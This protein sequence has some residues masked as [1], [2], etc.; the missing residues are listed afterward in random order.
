MNAPHATTAEQLRQHLLRLGV[1]G[2]LEAAIVTKAGRGPND[3]SLLFP[4]PLDPRDI[5]GVSFPSSLTSIAE[6]VV[7]TAGMHRVGQSTIGPRTLTTYARP[8]HQV[9]FLTRL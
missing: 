3:S 5:R 8:G 4:M 1:K 2:V 7:V 6:E 9:L